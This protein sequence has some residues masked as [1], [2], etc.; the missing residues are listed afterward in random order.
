M[1]GKHQGN[2]FAIPPTGR[3]TEVTAMNFYGLSGGQFVEERG[4]PDLLG[5]LQQIG[6]VCKSL[7]SSR[8]G[9][10]SDAPCSGFPTV[11]RASVL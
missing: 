10:M 11:D 8:I 4:Q 1:R 9:D 3:K 6:A 7:S 5:L 2:F